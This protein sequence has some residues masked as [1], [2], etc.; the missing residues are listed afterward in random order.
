MKNQATRKFSQK[1]QI[2]LQLHMMHLATGHFRTQ[3]IY[4]A[5][6]LGIADLLKDGS[7]TVDELSNA[8]KL[9][10]AHFTDSCVPLPA[11][12]FFEK[13]KTAAFV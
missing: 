12:I 5:A 9:M 13:R 4:V 2:P 11:L 8:T 10:L 7:K 3:A 6:K 1:D